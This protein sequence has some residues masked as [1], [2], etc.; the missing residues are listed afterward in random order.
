MIPRLSPVIQRA[1]GFEFESGY[2]IEKKTNNIW[3]KLNKGEVVKVYD[4]DIK[5]T[6]DDNS[7]GFSAIEI[8]LD[9]P[10]QETEPKKFSKALSTFVKLGTSLHAIKPKAVRVPVGFDQIMGL[11]GSSNYR[12]NPIG[13]DL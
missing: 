9:P 6:A 10:V 8:V 13:M 12:V 3:G 5:L 4:N 1:V 11:N 2:K 7:G